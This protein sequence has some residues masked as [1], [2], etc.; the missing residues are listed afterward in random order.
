MKVV[1]TQIIP[2]PIR[3]QHLIW[4]DH[5]VICSC[6]SVRSG[7]TVSTEATSLYGHIWWGWRDGDQRG[8][9]QAD[10]PR[11]AAAEG[12]HPHRDKGD[13]LLPAPEHRQLCGVLPGEQHAVRRDGVPRRGRT[14]RCRLLLWTSFYFLFLTFNLLL[15]LFIILP[16]FCTTF[17][18]LTFYSEI[19]DFLACFHFIL[20][21][22]SLVY[23]INQS[24]NQSTTKSIPNL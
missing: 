16:Y 11:E 22:S 5:L 8:G 18:K 2:S 3:L 14:H 9:N 19:L 4:A 7:V 21:A 6:R 20:Y 10:G 13:A 1:S 24:I 23:F 17:T 15:N 12:A